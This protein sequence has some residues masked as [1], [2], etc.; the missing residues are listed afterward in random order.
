M[1]SGAKKHTVRKADR[2]FKV[3]D[4]LLLREF[5][6]DVAMSGF[7]LDEES[8][9]SGKYTGRA[10]LRKITYITTP[11]SF[12]LPEDICVLS[13]SGEGGVSHRLR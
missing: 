4:S 7:I 8:K 5:Q 3:G 6:P 10:L 13:L 9:I 1:A 2:D 12:G 11:G